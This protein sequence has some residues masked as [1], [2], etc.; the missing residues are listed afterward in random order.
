M[1][2]HL[3]CVL[4]PW[5]HVEKG[6]VPTPESRTVGARKPP[7]ASLISQAVGGVQNPLRFSTQHQAE[8]TDLVFYVY[9]YHAGIPWFRTGIPR[10]RKSIN[11]FVPSFPWW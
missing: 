4:K 11:P 2:R 1:P 8:K 6:A 7:P 5:L 9:R 3:P 10:F